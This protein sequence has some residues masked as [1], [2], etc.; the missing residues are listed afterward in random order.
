[1]NLRFYALTDAIGNFLSSGCELTCVKADTSWA[2]WKVGVSPDKNVDLNEER[3]NPLKCLVHQKILFG[4]LFELFLEV[5][6]G[7]SPRKFQRHF[8][9]ASKTFQKTF[10]RDAQDFSESS[11]TTMQN[12]SDIFQR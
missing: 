11:Q 8:E 5:F 10:Q 1:M 4:N 9:D 3:R 6:V 2:F 7:G 12:I